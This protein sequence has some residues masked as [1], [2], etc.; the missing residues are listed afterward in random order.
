MSV[1]WGVGWW[2]RVATEEVEWKRRGKGTTTKK[3]GGYE[4]K[5]ETQR[6]SRRSATRA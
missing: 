3:E 2:Y 4:K 5:D 1:L 6:D